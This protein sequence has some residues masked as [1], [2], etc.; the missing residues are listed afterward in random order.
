MYKIYVKIDKYA[1]YMEIHEKYLFGLV[2]RF[3]EING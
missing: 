1:R 2:L 3:T